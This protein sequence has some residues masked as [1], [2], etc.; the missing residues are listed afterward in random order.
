ME[1]KNG[2]VSVIISSI[3]SECIVSPTHVTKRSPARPMSYPVLSCFVWTEGRQFTKASIV[4]TSHKDR[5]TQNES[6][7]ASNID[8]RQFVLC[9]FICLLSFIDF[10]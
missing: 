5:D 9:V 8:L 2:D 4:P 6:A 7:V 3:V 10:V 1:E